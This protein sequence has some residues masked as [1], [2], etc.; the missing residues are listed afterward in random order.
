M[1]MIKTTRV[2]RGMLPVA[3]LALL[4]AGCGTE[5]PENT[6]D[7]YRRSYPTPT[8]ISTPSTLADF[9]CPD[10]SPT[11]APTRTADT[12]GTAA[13]GDHYAENHGFRVPF[14]L[15]GRRRCDGLAAVGRIK[16]ALEPLRQRGDLAP[17]HTRSALT[18]LGYPAEK[19]QA[20]ENGPTGTG[21]LIEIDASP[22]CV[23]GTMNRDST[24]ADAFGG[25]PDHSGCDTPN[26]GH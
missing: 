8:G 9:P 25:Y 4:A 14:P 6:A 10:E 1:T 5:R 15:H 12:P 26:G 18:S 20:Y 23:E 17:E 24:R 7:E 2:R 16:A 3:V 22:L 11:P 21:F 13:P 19:V